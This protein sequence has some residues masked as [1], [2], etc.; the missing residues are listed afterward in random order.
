MIQLV[1]NIAGV[2]GNKDSLS[3]ESYQ[4]NRL[5]APSFTKPNLYKDISPPSLLSK[6]DHKK[7][8]EL[9]NKLSKY[10]TQYFQPNLMEI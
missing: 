5:E 3:N 1:G 10:K 4:N 8:A 7:I 9:K 6:G 2:L